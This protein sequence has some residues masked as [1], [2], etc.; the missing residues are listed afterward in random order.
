MK[1]LLL[2]LVFLSGC[3]DITYSNTENQ[4][5][6]LWEQI[7][8]SQND[9]DNV[10]LSSN[11]LMESGDTY[12]KKVTIYYIHVDENVILQC[13][14]VLKASTV[15]T[16]AYAKL[17]INYVA[18]G[19]V[20]GIEI[21]NDEASQLYNTAWGMPNNL[22]IDLSE[23]ELTEGVGYYV[24]LQLKHSDSNPSNYT[25]VYLSKIAVYNN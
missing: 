11:Y 7:A 16:T 9:G 22:F 6:V 17:T 15:F 24:T 14:L 2:V 8:S 20:V 3:G 1:Y 18:S 10:E 21:A 13:D 25:K 4:E 23:Q 5:T 19:G 12:K